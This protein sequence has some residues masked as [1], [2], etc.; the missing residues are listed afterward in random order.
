M[1]SGRC[2]MLFKQRLSDPPL[3]VLGDE[4]L[5]LS[6]RRGEVLGLVRSLG[7]FEI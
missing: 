3:A 7:I 4:S 5:A 1:E 6:P 2:L